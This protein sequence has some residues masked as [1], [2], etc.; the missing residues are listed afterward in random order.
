MK[1]HN[2]IAFEFKKKL[3]LLSVLVPDYCTVLVVTKMVNK[4]TPAVI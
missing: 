4:R 1:F 2:N 3:S